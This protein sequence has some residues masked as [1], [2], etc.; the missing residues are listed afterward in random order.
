MALSVKY[1]DEGLG[2][3]AEASG[4][5]TGSE[6]LTAV[7]EVNSGNLAE[8]PVLYTFFDFNGVMAVSIS[9]DH[10][11]AAAYLA[12]KGSRDQSARRVIAIYAQDDLPFALARMW[13]ILV[14]ETGWETYVF[15]TRPEAT[16]WLQERVGANHGLQVALD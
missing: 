2:V 8:K 13:Q 5:L 6:L 4:N 9:T 14:N 7:T 1:L 15:R 12:I 10:I 3:V 16:K 11:R